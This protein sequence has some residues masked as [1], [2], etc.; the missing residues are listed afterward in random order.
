VAADVNRVVSD[1]NLSALRSKILA[2][3]QLRMPREA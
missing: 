1:Q 3:M 2:G